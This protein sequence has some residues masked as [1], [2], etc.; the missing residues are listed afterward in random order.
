[1][2]YHA[3]S[4]YVTSMGNQLDTINFYLYIVSW[5]EFSLHDEQEDAMN[6]TDLKIERV[7]RGLRQFMVAA[8]LGWPPTTLWSIEAGRRPVSPEEAERIMQAIRKLST[9]SSIREETT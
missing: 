7:R 5:V 4:H 2:F 8:A 6:G 3:W 1:M 9:P